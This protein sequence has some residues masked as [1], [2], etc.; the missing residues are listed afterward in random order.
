M[1]SLS[2]LL[3]LLL[4]INCSSSSDV[5]KYKDDDP[6]SLI[7][8]WEIA[9][10]TYAEDLNGRK[11]KDDFTEEEINRMKNN[12]IVFEDGGIV[13]A[14]VMANVDGK[15]KVLVSKGIYEV[16]VETKRV[17]IEIPV[18]YEYN[19]HGGSY[20]WK[21]KKNKLYLRSTNDQGGDKVYRR[22]E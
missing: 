7:G 18:E 13:T 4:F 16:D 20:F 8:K 1:K 22:A 2:I 19:Y 12:Y 14:S 9:D 17:R 5:N 3:L 11:K 21:I 15:D 10:I 6:K